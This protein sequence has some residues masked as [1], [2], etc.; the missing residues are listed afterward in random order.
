MCCV[1]FENVNFH[2]YHIFSVI[3]KSLWHWS[4]LVVAQ[5]IIATLVDKR[6]GVWFK[7]LRFSFIQH[8]SAK[9]WFFNI[10][11]IIFK[12]IKVFT[13]YRLCFKSFSHCKWQIYMSFWFLLWYI[14]SG[15]LQQIEGCFQY[16]RAHVTSKRDINL[17]NE[18]GMLVKGGVIYLLTYNIRKA[19]PRI[20]VQKSWHIVSHIKTTFRGLYRINVYAEDTYTKYHIQ[21]NALAMVD[22]VT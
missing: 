4:L 11:E 12:I 22:W 2:C 15:F 17:W 19:R 9:S 8:N 3:D 13:V 14:L 18:W 5:P 21:S 6:D 10:L 1:L 20:E 16:E 7:E